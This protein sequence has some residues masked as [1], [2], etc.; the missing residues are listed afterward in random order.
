MASTKRL[1]TL[2]VSVIAALGLVQGMLVILAA[3][4][5]AAPIDTPQA[6]VVQADCEGVGEHD[7]VG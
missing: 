3:S 2:T 5:G 4:A 7:L 6:V 1:R